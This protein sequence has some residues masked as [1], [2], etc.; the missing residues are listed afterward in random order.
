MLI[1]DNLSVYFNLLKTILGAALIKYPYLFG[2][3]GI[4][5]VTLIS[6]VSI[7]FAFFGLILYT[8]LNEV[9]NYE[10][11]LSSLSK[12]SV[13]VNLIVGVKSFFVYILYL[14]IL[15]D[16]FMYFFLAGIIF[17]LSVL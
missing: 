17:F 8:K 4:V 15:N 2:V 7:A 5:P 16:L 1:S 10:I 9:N 12:N 11:N 13:F 6:F 3:V 14:R